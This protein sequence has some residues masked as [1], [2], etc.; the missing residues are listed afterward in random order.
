MYQH[1]A[2][3]I[4]YSR[5]LKFTGTRGTDPTDERWMDGWTDESRS[6][7]DYTTLRERAQRVGRVARME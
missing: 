5:L 3:A 1:N 7:H 4:L 6:F 2:A